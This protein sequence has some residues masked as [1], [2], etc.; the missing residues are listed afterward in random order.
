MATDRFLTPQQLK[1]ICPNVNTTTLKYWSNKGV[2][3]TQ[4]RN[5]NTTRK[6]YLYS[7]QDTKKVMSALAT[8]NPQKGNNGEK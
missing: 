8:L 5:P 3:A 7:E 1:V 2:I 4:V 6:L